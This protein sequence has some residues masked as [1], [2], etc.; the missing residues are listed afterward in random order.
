MADALNQ[1][2]ERSKLNLEGTNQVKMP[3]L[4][5]G[6]DNNRT[7][8]EDHILVNSE[9]QPLK[10]TFSGPISLADSDI[11]ICI[12]GRDIAEFLNPSSAVDRLMN[13]SGPSIRLNRTGV[14]RFTV[15]GIPNG[16]YN[17][18]V[19]DNNSSKALMAMPL[20]ITQGNLTLHSPV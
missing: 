6:Q 12:L 7:Y 11:R 17:L 5:I 18:F 3:S 14:A 8:P 19:V 9:N 1:T 15:P 10:G 2:D 13:C 20:L 4:R 16:T